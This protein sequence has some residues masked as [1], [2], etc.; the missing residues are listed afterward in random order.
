MVLAAALVIPWLAEAQVVTRPSDRVRT[1]LTFLTT[2][3]FPPF[4]YVDEEGVLTGFNVD[5]ARAVCLELSLRCNIAK[6][7]WPHLFPRLNRR[8]GDAV[9][10]GHM[11]SAKALAEV[12]FTD[13]YF[14]TP[15]R[16]A[17]RRD[18]PKLEITPEGLE[19]KRIGVANGT[20]HAAFVGDFFKESAIVRFP[21]QELARDALIARKVD[22]VFD[23]G[24]SMVLWLNGTL[25]RAC[26]EL[27][28][29]AFLEP[30][31]FGEGVAIAV[32]KKD[33]ELRN[34][35]NRALQRIRES[36][37]LEELML[38]YFPFR[39]L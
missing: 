5:V 34:Q 17:A 11:I 15:G 33:D 27:R 32:R 13:S 35:L 6:A 18:L 10:A 4:N 36:G 8:L 23:D 9:I 21:S 22:L 24:V 31:Y 7:E 29:G 20:T 39:L 30:R 1:S 3:D 38:R 19:G 25:S 2:E 14:F 12:N 26:C 37:R 16:F 28:G